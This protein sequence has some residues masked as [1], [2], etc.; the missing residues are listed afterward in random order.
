MNKNLVFRILGIVSG[1]LVI[2]S[3]FLPYFSLSLWALNAKQHNLYLSVVMIVFAVLP[4]ILYAINKK[5]EFA[6]M[7]VGALAFFLVTQIVDALSSNNLG[8]L[9][10]GFYLLIISVIMMAVSTLILSKGSK[11]NIL[12]EQIASDT[13]NISDPLKSSGVDAQIAETKGIVDEVSPNAID[14]SI[15]GIPELSSNNELPEDNNSIVDSHS[16]L[17]EEIPEFQS[18]DG[19]NPVISEFTSADNAVAS[20]DNQAKEAEFPSET[21]VSEAPVSEAPNPVVEEAVNNVENPET[22]SEN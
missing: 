9:G 20:N 14:N 2:V 7:S 8:A 1:L 17:G 16:V 13:N 11:I 10:I 5:M 3:L 21:P 12:N 4:I 18:E 15:E 22:V 6:Y 19:I